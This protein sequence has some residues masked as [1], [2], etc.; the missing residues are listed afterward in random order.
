MSYEMKV[1][2][3]KGNSRNYFENFL[4]INY[5]FDNGLYFFTQLEYSSPP[6]LGIETKSIND[7]LNMFYLQYSTNKYDLTLGNLYLLYGRGLSIHSYEDQNIDY[8]NSLMGIDFIYHINNNIDI[9]TFIGEKNIK[10]RFSPTIKE[11]DISIDNQVISIGS[12]MNFSNIN[13]HY[14]S[15]I[16]NQKY[17]NNDILILKD[18][19][20][21]LGKYLASRSYYI[22]SQEKPNYDMLNFEHNFGVEFAIGP[23]DFYFEKSLVYYDKILGER[24]DGYKNYFSS[25]FN[26]FDFNIIYEYKDYFTPYLYN[27]FSTPPIA[28]RESTS[29][30][31]SRNLHTID[32]SNEYGYQLE[33]NKTYDNSANIL[34]SYA[35]ATHHQNYNN[36]DIYLLDQYPYKQYYIETSKWSSSERFYY[37]IGY[38][39]YQE[40]L[41][42][43]SIEAS[44][45]PMQ[46]AYNFKKGNSTTFYIE[47]Q[48]KIEGGKEYNYYYFSPSYNHFGKWL[49]TLFVDS[50]KKTINN[51]NWYA[52][53]YT[54][55]LPNSAQISLFYGSQKGGLICANGSCVIQPD[56][57]DGFKATYRMNF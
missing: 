12:S 20:N 10:S 35:F 11:P 39:Y 9:F 19:Q 22:S 32:F 29:I 38:D 40:K 3:G 34:F 47:M 49:I 5:F 1:A 13:F 6:L 42:D 25:Y 56:F 16:N 15:M 4:D 45:M 37:R 18:F 44:T 50:E 53:D 36:D 48:D 21:L 30:L 31:S 51:Q 54:I 33:I 26:I 55:N 8:D 28:F 23:L 57:E 14:L 24:V 7:M 2:E 41:T 27:V 43:K 52:V 46:F 17:D